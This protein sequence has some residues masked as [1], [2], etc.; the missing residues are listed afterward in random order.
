MKMLKKTLCVFM[1]VLMLFSALS[2]SLYAAAAE[3]RSDTDYRALAYSFFNYTIKSS[4][5]SSSYVVT[6]D[7]NGNPVRSL[8]GDLNQYTISN[9]SGE[10]E[11]A[12]DEG[13][14]IRA[15]SF[16]HQVTAKDNSAGLIRGAATAYLSIVDGIMST[17][18]G[19]GLYTVP[20][21]ADA[22]AE[23]LKFTKGDDGEYLF[24]DGYTY[25]VD[26]VGNIKARSPEKTYEVVDGEIVELETDDSWAEEYNNSAYTLMDLFEFC[27]VSTVIDYFSGNCTSINSGNWF[28]T[29]TFIC[30]TDIETVLVTES[31]VNKPVTMNSMTV[32][33]KLRR[34]Y[35]ESG[36]KAQYYNAG[37]TVD[38]GV[39]GTDNTRVE[40]V[41]L[42]GALDQYFAD[43]ISADS[44][45]SVM[46]DRL[47]NINLLS[48]HYEYITRYYD[49][50][51]SVSNAAKLAVFG[52]NAYSYVNLVTQLTPIVNSNSPTDN[53]YWPKHTYSKYQDAQGNDIVYQVDAQKVTSIVSTIDDLL[54]SERVGSI[55]KQFFDYTDPQY[56]DMAYYEDAQNAKTA[57]DVLKVFIADF[58]YN[59]D[60]INML[61]GLLYPMVTNLLD[62]LITNEMINGVLN[63]VFSGL[64]AI[65]EWVVEDSDGWLALIYGVLS[66]IGVG[67]TPAGVAYVWNR[68]D[69]KVF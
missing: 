37:Y 57:Q 54:K 43:Y 38:K 69:S 64:D 6:R 68:Y 20:M 23:T 34:Q 25:A 46:L 14:P 61:L 33:W 3:V 8:V 15:V 18:Y 26:A 63:D 1:S 29:Y 44:S 45:G 16:D 19:V 24:L 50:F 67:L 31:L 52:Q 30:K 32:S 5:H 21:I 51:A 9:A 55:I 59:D 11:Y 39:A 66:S 48:Y 49:T 27:H 12:D 17:E 4:A 28:H 13:M 42:Q 22:V 56:E 40:L 65:V 36:T 58:L 7:E 60:I 10:Y 41:T 47:T 2:V 62:D 35:D 53:T